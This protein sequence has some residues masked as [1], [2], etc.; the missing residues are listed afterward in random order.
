MSKQMQSVI[1][2]GAGIIGLSCGYHL[3][4]KG[5]GV[6]IVEENKPGIGQS[7]KTGGGIRYFH[8]SD[9]NV[10]MSF[11]SQKFWEKFYETFNIDPDY[12]KTGH[13]FLTSNAQVSQDLYNSSNHVGLNLEILKKSQIQVRWPH[14]SGLKLEYGIY[15]PLGGYLDHKKAI[16]G[17]VKGFK[18]L[19]GVIRLGVKARSLIKI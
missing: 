1:V 15:C 9:E 12:Q 10:E 11:V 17:L 6:T 14:L 2:V 13:L 5:L 7:T 4:C 18:S 19:G 8:G 16:E 3:A